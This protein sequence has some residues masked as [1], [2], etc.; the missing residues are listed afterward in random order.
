MNDFAE[1][2]VSFWNLML[3]GAAMAS[4]TPL[5]GRGPEKLG[6]KQRLID[7]NIRNTSAKLQLQTWPEAVNV[8]KR[9]AYV[10]FEGEQQLKSM[11]ERAMSDMDRRA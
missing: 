5:S 2:T 7:R 10:E 1:Q 11:W 4:L 6:R 8:L 3:S 9:V